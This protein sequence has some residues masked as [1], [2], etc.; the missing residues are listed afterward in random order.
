MKLCDILRNTSL[1]FAG[2]NFFA[3]TPFTFVPRAYDYALAT[4]SLTGGALHSYKSGCSDTVLKFAAKNSTPST[5]RMIRARAVSGSSGHAHQQGRRRFVR[6]YRR[7]KTLLVLVVCINHIVFLGGGQEAC[8]F[9]F[10]RLAL[11]ERR[12]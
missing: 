4:S 11:T 8:R 10:L 12:L 3:I 1:W 5:I 2:R 7:I 6:R 9:Y